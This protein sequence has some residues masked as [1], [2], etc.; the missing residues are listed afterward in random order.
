MREPFQDPLIEEALHWLVI[1][2]DGHASRADRE[3]F[4]QWLNFDSSH[5]AAWRRAQHVWMK[6]E[7][8]GAAFRERPRPFRA[9]GPPRLVAA[10]ALPPPALLHPGRRRVLFGAGALAGLAVPGALLASRGRRFG[11]HA[12]AV[13]ERR[14]VILDDGSEIEMAGASSLSVD[15]LA[16]Q[17]RIVLHR[18]EAAFDVVQDAARPF[19]VHA[20]EGQ[21]RALETAFDVKIS[22]GLVTVAVTEDSV[23]V[24]AH[25]AEPVN[26]NEGLLVRYGPSRVGTVQDA[27]LDQ[28]EAW[29][30]DR[31]VFQGS[32]LGE[33][34]DDLERYRAGRIVLTDS[35]LRT[36]PVTGSFEARDTDGVLDAVARTLPVRVTRLAGLL[37][38]LSSRS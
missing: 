26:V 25:G 31:L 19:V 20:A 29:R 22:D 28:V 17:R 13:G 12:T 5:R 7:R 9:S 27:D 30:H 18:G 3:A 15:F 38:V 32:P 1:L 8:V 35:S 36:L 11:A 6:V 23:L 14:T 21:T 4:D 10:P 37:V 34:I 2:E 33:V 24:S 16:D